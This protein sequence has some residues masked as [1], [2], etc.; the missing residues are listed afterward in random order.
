MM[1]ELKTSDFLNNEIGKLGKTPQFELPDEFKKIWAPTGLSLEEINRRKGAV[2]QIQQ[3]NNT[4]SQTVATSNSGAAA[5]DHVFA[6]SGCPK[7]KRRFIYAAELTF[8]TLNTGAA[9]WCNCGLYPNNSATAN[10]MGLITI[11]LPAN[12]SGWNAQFDTATVSFPIPIQWNEG[13][14]IGIQ[15]IF[16]QGEA[17]LRVFYWEEDVG[18]V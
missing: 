9:A 13:E 6:S 1:A 5:T 16:F 11:V 10:R 12:Y 2:R 18:I 8:Y 7:N 4:G 3:E 17:Q 15:R 14:F